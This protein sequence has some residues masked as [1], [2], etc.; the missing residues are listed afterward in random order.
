MIC[1][2]VPTKIDLYTDKLVVLDAQD[3]RIVPFHSIPLGHF[4]S[5]NDFIIMF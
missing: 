4:I 1:Q 5:Y 2:N 3:F